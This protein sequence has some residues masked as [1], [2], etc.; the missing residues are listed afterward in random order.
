MLN[1]VNTPQRH[2]LRRT[3][4][5]AVASLIGF[6][7]LTAPA[8]AQFGSQAGFAEAFQKDFLRRDMQLFVDYLRLEDW[9]R[10]IIEVLLDDYQIT[11]DAGTEA[12]KNQMANLKEEMLADPENAMEIAL[13]PIKEW[14]TEKKQMSLEFEENI[15]AQLSPLQ[16]QR[17]PSLERAMRREKELPLGE[18]PGER[19]NVFVVLH[20]MEL[21]PDDLQTIDPILLDYEI[22]LDA[23]LTNRRTQM[24]RYQPKLQDAMVSKDYTAGLSGLR[25]I[26]EARAGVTQAHMDAIE[27]IARSLPMSLGDEFR[28]TVLSRGYPDIYKSNSVDRLLQAARNLPD[29]TPEQSSGLDQIEAEYLVSLADSNERLLQLYQVYGKEIPVLEAKQSIARRNKEEVKRG[30]NVPPQITDEQ[31]NR[32]DMLEGYRMR[33]RDLLTPEQIAII[34]SSAMF[35]R[36]NRESGSD[37]RPAALKPNRNRPNSSNNNVHPDKQRR[38]GGRPGVGGVSP[39]NPPSK[40]DD[41]PP[42]NS[43]Q[44]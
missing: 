23:A 31:K 5:M 33:I 22:R 36:R 18:L 37:N 12:C 13:R 9:Q 29:L 17:W 16:M 2:T 30:S 42:K 4:A 8:S 44:R 1:E 38:K 27:S 26:S 43:N 39:T 40:L 14:E 32:S 11:F 34:P 10:P 41:S 25:N 28:M 21:K 35:D 15:R 19:M 20:G 3:L 24:D 6:C 7:M